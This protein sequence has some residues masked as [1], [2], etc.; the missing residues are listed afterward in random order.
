MNAESG[1]GNLWYQKECGVGVTNY[2]CIGLAGAN[3][4]Q[5]RH[6]LVTHTWLLERL[7]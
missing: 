3:S 7:I 5:D 6:F 4:F 1:K 2:I